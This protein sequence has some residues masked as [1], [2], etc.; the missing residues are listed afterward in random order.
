MKQ[1]HLSVLLVIGLAS[2]GSSTQDL[3]ESVPRAPVTVVLVRHAET[4]G[5]GAQRVLSDEGRQRAAAL[6]RLLGHAGVTHLY[7]SPYARTRQTLGPLAAATKLKVVEVSPR[8]AGRQVELLAGLPPG[9]LAVVAGHSNT[10]PDLVAA[11]GGEVGDREDSP[12]GAVI[13]ED[14]HDRLFVV[15]LPG[16]AGAAPGTLEL[17]VGE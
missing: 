8:E 9:S 17:R 7:S 11:L 10:V 15:T 3:A 1:S 16:V 2:L 4:T 12:H 13:A 5:E 6:G 14:Q